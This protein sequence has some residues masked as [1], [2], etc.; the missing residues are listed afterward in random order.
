M[1][2]TSLWVSCTEP[3]NVPGLD[4]QSNQ[5]VVDAVFTSE[6]R[7]HVIYLSRSTAITNTSFPKETGAIVYLMDDQGNRIDFA[8]GNPGSYFS[9]V[10][11]AQPG[12]TYM[13]YVITAN[14]NRYVSLPETLTG[15]PPPIKNLTSFD[16]SEVDG[17]GNVVEFAQIEITL[18]DPANEENFYYWYWQSDSLGQFG[19]P[20]ISWR[21]ATDSD[22]LFNGNEVV[23]ALEEEFT[24]SVDRFVKIYQATI[25]RDAYVF[26]SSIKRQIGN[27]QIPIFPPNRPLESN[28]V[29]END[30]KERV[31]GYFVLANVTADTIRL[32]P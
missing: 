8:E 26:L 12:Q 18:D 3:I 9:T 32:A 16:D 22:E 15:T 6:N 19:I 24:R 29:N 23:F 17:N 10:V 31:L 11:A 21:S 13:L 25:N 28:L 5:L 30:P 14:G 2:F 1:F 4:D 20:D 27:E 7:V